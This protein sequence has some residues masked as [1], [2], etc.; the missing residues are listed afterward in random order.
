[1]IKYTGFIRKIRYYSESSHYI[2]AL[3]EVEEEQKLITMNGYMSNFNEYD[4]YLF[5]GN[6]EIHPK[7]GQQLKLDHYEVVLSTDEDEMIKMGFKSMPML[8]VD[9]VIYSFRDAYNLI[10]KIGD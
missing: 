3:L 2:V 7:Y 10:E 4:K 1:M 5:Y 9:G 8:S 6:Y